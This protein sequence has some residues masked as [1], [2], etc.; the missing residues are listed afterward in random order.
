MSE[1]IKAVHA[2]LRSLL[3]QPKNKKTWEAILEELGDIFPAR[4]D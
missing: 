3:Q 2:E 4:R 1:K